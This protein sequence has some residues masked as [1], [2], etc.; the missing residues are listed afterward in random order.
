MFEFITLLISKSPK[1]QFLIYLF[2]TLS[3]QK[4]HTLTSK[5]IWDTLD[6]IDNNVGITGTAKLELFYSWEKK[7]C[8]L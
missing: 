7:N 3:V 4:L 5:Q 2:F 6:V 8:I 1:N